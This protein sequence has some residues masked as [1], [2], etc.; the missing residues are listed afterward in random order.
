MMWTVLSTSPAARKREG[1]SPGGTPAKL[2][3]T[4]SADISFLSVYSFSWPDW[5][6]GERVRG[7]RLSNIYSPMKYELFTEQEI[8][9]DILKKIIKTGS[10]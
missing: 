2:I 8:L 7:E 10:K 6:G 5:G 4:T 1:C 9:L 3:H